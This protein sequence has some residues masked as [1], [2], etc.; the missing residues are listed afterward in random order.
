LHASF[1]QH[2]ERFANTRR[3]AKEILGAAAIVVEQIEIVDDHLSS[4]EQSFQHGTKGQGRK[5]AQSH[6]GYQTGGEKDIEQQRMG[7]KSS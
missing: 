1:T 5:I 3:L 4:E 7:R 2:A 6:H